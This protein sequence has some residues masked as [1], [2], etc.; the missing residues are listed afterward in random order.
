VIIIFATIY[1]GMLVSPLSV[2]GKIKRETDLT[3]D[4][5]IQH[6]LTDKIEKNSRIITTADFLPKLS[7]GKD[8]YSLHYVFLGTKQFSHKEYEIPENID[9]MLVNFDEFKFYYFQYLRKTMFT[10]PYL[11]GDN[12]I[13]DLIEKQGFNIDEKIGPYVLYKKGNI[14]EENDNYKIISENSFKKDYNVNYE[15]EHGIT[16]LIA[17][18]KF[19]T[20]RIN[21]TDIDYLDLNLYWNIK[22]KVDKNYFVTITLMDTENN[23][24]FVKNIPFGYGLYPLPEWEPENIIYTNYQILIPNDFRNFLRNQDCS[25]SIAVTDIKGDA[26]FNYLG[27]VE[28]SVFESSEKGR[29]EIK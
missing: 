15:F 22:N 13:R 5:E 14:S 27:S 20:R 16:L 28:L 4:T 23:K 11:E 24:K 1:T 26:Y 2:F 19:K 21:E 9:Y 25:V 8:I 29:I 6:Y 17:E 12:R 10:E 18:K 7:S 3:N